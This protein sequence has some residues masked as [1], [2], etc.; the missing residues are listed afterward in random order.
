MVN[1]WLY[2]C[3]DD[4]LRAGLRQFQA[5]EQRHQAARQEEEERHD[6]VQMPIFL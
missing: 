2:V 6:D 5:D 3:A 1:S 4:D